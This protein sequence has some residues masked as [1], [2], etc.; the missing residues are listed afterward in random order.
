ML[1]R[2]RSST[3]STACG[4]SLHSSICLLLLKPFLT[5]SF[6]SEV[7]A[8]M[9]LEA[10]SSDFEIHQRDL[11]DLHRN[12][13]VLLTVL[14]KT[15]RLEPWGAYFGI[16]FP[17]SDYKSLV[18]SWNLS[19][20]GFCKPTRFVNIFSHV[21]PFFFSASKTNQDLKRVLPNASR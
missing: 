21:S 14:R 20:F 11:N 18:D 6:T 16:P 4:S 8:S 15:L 10:G 3:C 19:A 7:C 2:T 12:C 13:F 9:W 17:W 5:S 1:R